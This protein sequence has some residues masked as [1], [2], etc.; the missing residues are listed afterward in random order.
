[1]SS[2][3]EGRQPALTV[4]D[5]FTPRIQPLGSKI[6]EANC[7]E[8]YD[9]FVWRS[10]AGGV[11]TITFVNQEPNEDIISFNGDIGEFICTFFLFH[12][13]CL[14]PVG[15]SGMDPPQSSFCPT[16]PPYRCFDVL[17]ALLFQLFATLGYLV[18]TTK[19]PET[20]VSLSFARCATLMLS[21]S[22]LGLS[23]FST[24]KAS[25]PEMKCTV[26]RQSSTLQSTSFGSNSRE[27]RS[28]A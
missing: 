5:R 23:L 25:K 21:T 10:V 12:M 2:P 24:S 28:L 6:D 11:Q 26:E 17:I 27:C 1:M 4:R 22:H 18:E 3:F 14:L 7:I 8:G 19:I 20:Y 9:W 13:I 15:A 16:T